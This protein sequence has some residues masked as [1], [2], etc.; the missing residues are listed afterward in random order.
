V[1]REQIAYWLDTPTSVFGGRSSRE[2]IRD[3]VLSKTR[4]AG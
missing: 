2:M 3:E 1:H 4:R